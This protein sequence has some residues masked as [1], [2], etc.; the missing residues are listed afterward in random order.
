MKHKKLFIS[1]TAVISFFVALSIFLGVWFLADTYE[2]FAKSFSKEFAIPGLDEGAVPQG[3]GN[4]E[5]AYDLKDED[6]VII[7]KK[8]QYFFISA[9]MVDKSPSRIY[10]TGAV[11][12]Y[13]GYVTMKNLDGTDYTGHCGGI[14]ANGNGSTVWVTGENT[15]YVAKSSLY[16]GNEYAYTVQ[17]I[18]DK[19]LGKVTD[20]DGNTDRAIHFTSAFDANCSASF[21][22]YYDDP[23]SGSLSADKLYV[24]EFYRKGNYKTDESHHLTTP[25]GYKN[26]A[27]MYEYQVSS[28]STAEYG[29]STLNSTNYATVD[30]DVPRIYKI[31][32]I[33]ELVQ[34]V[35]V[36]GSNI[37]LSQSYGL[38]NSE[39]TLYD[40]T[41]V[42]A[43]AVNYVDKCKPF[44]YNG[45]YETNGGVQTQYYDNS[46]SLK[47]YYVDKNDNEMLKTNYSIPSMSEG[48]C[49]VATTSNTR[50]Y[51]L[52]ESSG[53][54]YRLFVRE[55]L[56]DVYSV[57]IKN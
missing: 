36:A 31:Y 48:L 55:R 49:S 10:V 3:M 29:L 42:N 9:Y 57:R 41:K 38:A 39:I 7:S 32:S 18:L 5:F 19:A 21:C 50:V 14:A 53:K 44:A 8:Q 45:V 24:G 52:F 11:T 4:C 16:E 17:E 20:G 27:F 13:V 12:G 54:K 34:G 56:S 51:V 2:S 35:A 30:N 22:Y 47:L 25:K 23:N 37:V 15:V 40:N 28:D 33:P 6:G 1:L 26:H 46:T 43:S